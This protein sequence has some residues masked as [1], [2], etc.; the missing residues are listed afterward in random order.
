MYHYFIFMS[1]AFTFFSTMEY[2]IA[3]TNICFHFTASMEFDDLYWLVGCNGGVVQHDCISNNSA[4]SSVD[5]KQNWESLS[6][7]RAI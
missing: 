5:K 4:T 3:I 1:I 2:A 7:C 6:N